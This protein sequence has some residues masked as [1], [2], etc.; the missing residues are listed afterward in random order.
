M[1]VVLCCHYRYFRRFKLWLI[2]FL[3]CSYV[4][5]KS[6]FLF[7]IYDR[8]LSLLSSLLV[9]IDSSIVSFVS[10]LLCIYVNSF[11]FLRL[12]V[13]LL[14][15]FS[16]FETYGRL[17]KK[18]PDKILKHMTSYHAFFTTLF[19]LLIYINMNDLWGEK[20]EFHDLTLPWHPWPP[21]TAWPLDLH[22]TYRTTRI[23]SAPKLLSYSSCTTRESYSWWACV[24]PLHDPSCFWSTWRAGRCTT[25]FIIPRE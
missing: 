23:T 21:L 24:R 17:I 7:V 4:V 10:H 16:F 25:S 15:F 20:N 5:F 11:V 22:D 3:I 13:I 19:L 8:V 14:T 9:I 1:S 18:Y 12:F 2:L 6:I